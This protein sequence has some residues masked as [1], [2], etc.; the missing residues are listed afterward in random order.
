MSVRQGSQRVAGDRQWADTLMVIIVSGLV[1][2]L[3]ALV[4][5]ISFVDDAGTTP[6]T[7]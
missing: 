3:F 6:I 7:H 1:A 2:T 4:G 5:Y